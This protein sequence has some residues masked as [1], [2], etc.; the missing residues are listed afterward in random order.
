[1][2]FLSELNKSFRLK[3]RLS[4]MVIKKSC[5]SCWKLLT[6]NDK[7]CF[8]N[9]DINVYRSY[10]EQ[11][12]LPC[13]SQWK[14]KSHL[15]TFMTLIELNVTSKSDFETF[16]FAFQQSVAIKPCS[17]QPSPPPHPC[18]SLHLSLSP[19]SHLLHSGSIKLLPNETMSLRS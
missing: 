7:K 3:G 15:H 4:L 6:Q 13:E 19:Y 18:L 1:M 17:S 14:G 16:Q 8:R 11:F 2:C 10:K 9:W 5:S 12:T